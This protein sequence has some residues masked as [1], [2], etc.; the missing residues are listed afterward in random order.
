MSFLVAATLLIMSVAS[1]YL[2]ITKSIAAWRLQ[3]DFK[4]YKQQFWNA[5]NLSAA[6]KIE[7]NIAL[8]ALAQ[9]A[10]AAAEHHKLHVSKNAENVTQD[11]L[12]EELH[13]AGF[14]A[15]EVSGNDH[16]K[17][18]YAIAERPS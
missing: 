13:Y 12:A 4:S 16:W 1:W 10:V 14:V 15:I 17:D 7:Q 8:S 3:A 18:T 2:I 11:E 6:L 5:P 9:K